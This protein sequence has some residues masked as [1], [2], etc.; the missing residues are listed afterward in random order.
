MFTFVSDGSWRGGW[1]AGGGCGGVRRCRLTGS[2]AERAGLARGSPGWWCWRGLSWLA[3]RRG[4]GRRVGGGDEIVGALA[5]AL[6]PLGWEPVG[7]ASFVGGL[8]GGV[9][10]VDA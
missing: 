9:G 2:G 4:S 5:A 8:A 3:G 10:V 7:G 1:R 6:A